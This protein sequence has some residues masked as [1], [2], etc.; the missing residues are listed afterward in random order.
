M[1]V[2]YHWG[3]DKLGDFLAGGGTWETLP[4]ARQQYVTDILRIAQSLP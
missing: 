3:P 2:A 4:V 1:L